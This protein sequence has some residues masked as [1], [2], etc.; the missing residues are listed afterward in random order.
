MMR[1]AFAALLL[2]CVTP[3]WGEQKQSELQLTLPP[4]I[5][6]VTGVPTH[7]Y[8]DNIVLTQSPTDYRFEVTC[9]VGKIADRRWELTPTAQD[10]G[11][12]PLRVAVYSAENKLLESKS[13]VLKV[14]ADDDPQQHDP[15]RLLIIG[16]SLTHA[17]A[18]PN[19][20]ARLLSRQNN[21]KWTMLGTH[22][23]SSA[24]EGVVHEGYGGWTWANFV[25]KYDPNPDDSHAKRSS[26]FLFLDENSKPQLNLPRYFQE[27][28]E[29]QRPDY[30]VIK[31]GINDCFSAPVDDRG[32]MDARID[33]VFG[34][35][36]RLLAAIREAAPQAHI[37]ICLTTPGNDRPEAFK[38]NYK[39]RYTRW[40][41]KQIQHH[42]VQRQM[43]YVSEKQDPMI[44]ILPTQ[45]NLDPIDGYPNNNAVH[46]NATGYKQIGASVY[47]WLKWKLANAQP[48]SAAAESVGTA[49]AGGE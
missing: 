8:F 40:G 11:D 7:I 26:P 33:T 23:P 18:Y 42:L 28:C 19:E 9:D 49:S 24:T 27:Q 3:V 30:V 4:E 29:D 15:I 6:A 47:A 2:Y 31:L 44:T 13:G 38:A 43:Q 34:F 41:W 36:D 22:K 48:A 14:I 12:H 39:D 35:A 45:L 46:P 37:G 25:T 16:D 17:S 10:V 32:G 21:P 20:I 1:L 5:Y